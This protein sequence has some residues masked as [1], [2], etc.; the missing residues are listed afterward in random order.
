MNLSD[1]TDISVSN[2]SKTAQVIGR[3]VRLNSHENLPIICHTSSVKNEELP[4][5]K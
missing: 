2:L 3:A 1:L 4:G 5:K